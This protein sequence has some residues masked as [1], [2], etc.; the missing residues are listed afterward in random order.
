MPPLAHA[1]ILASYRP[2]A[3]EADPDPIQR[4]VDADI[5][6]FPRIRDDGVMD[7]A[8]TRDDEDWIIGPYG[9]SQPAPVCPTCIPDVIL[10]P[11]LGFDRG[12]GRLGQGGGHYD[13][14]LAAHPDALAVGVAWA[15]QEVAA[16]PLEA[17]DR[18]LDHIVTEREWISV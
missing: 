9:V 14:A 4:H 5:L 8:R 12:G 16:V 7:F 11:L 2:I 17:W 3:N 15:V 1:R 13:R 10:V 6:C 18:R